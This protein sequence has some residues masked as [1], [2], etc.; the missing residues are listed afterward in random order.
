MTHIIFIHMLLGIGN[1]MAISIFKEE[2]K[3]NI[4]ICSEGD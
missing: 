2:K 3:C 1:Q 4:T